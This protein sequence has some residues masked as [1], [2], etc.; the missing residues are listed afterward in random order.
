M[1]EEKQNL[2]HSSETKKKEGDEG[3]SRPP[4]VVVLGHIDHGKTT[5]LDQIRQAHVADKESGGITQHV[6]AYE[7]EYQDKK[8][9][10]IDTPGH[11][12]FS[13][14]RS[15][16]VKVADIALLVVAADEGVKPQTKEAISHI[17]K[18]GIEPIIVINKI[19][20]PEADPEKVKRELSKEEILVESVG[21]KTPSVNVSAKTGQG[22]NDLLEMILL[23]TDMQGLKADPAKPAEGVIIEAYLDSQRGTT[24]TLLVKGGTLYSGDIIGTNSCFGKLKSL[25]DFRGMPIEKALPSMPT[26]VF[27]F[28]GIPQVGE[29]FKVF[30]N[31]ELAKSCYQPPESIPLPVSS[32][33]PAE[34]IL[35]IIIKSDFLGSLEAINKILGGLPQEKVA[36][37]ILKLE[38]GDINESDIKSA[39]ETGSKIFAFRV[40]TSSIIK[41]IAER[42]KVRI[43]NCETIYDLVEAVRKLMEKSLESEVTRIDLGKMKALAIFMTEKNRQIVGGKIVEGEV[44]RGAAVEVF[45]TEK[46]IGGG[47]II[48]LQRNKKDTDRVAKGDECGLLFEGNVKIEI[49]DL[50]AVYTEERNKGEL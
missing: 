16:S 25:L 41:S 7:V 5:L 40:K 50:L 18:S 46:N 24:A 45:R 21:G 10:F 12:A 26:V 47:K 32:G 29:E 1:V 13:A 49:D 35:N 30:P 48:N 23:V 2:I 9:T 20:K 15:R 37:K 6:G 8:I 3:V 19:D 14:I 28:E 17:K 22:I 42:E 27:G 34:K 44:K 36:L 39:K 4:V 31:I 33:Q 11:E 43:I 38:V